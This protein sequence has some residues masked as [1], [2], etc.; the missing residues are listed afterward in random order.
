V[1]N[2]T[3]IYD[4]IVVGGGT[5]GCVIASRL[6]EDPTVRVL[7]LEAGASEPL[8]AMST[9]PA[10]PTLVRSSASWAGSTVLQSSTGTAAFFPRGR[11]LGGSSSINAMLFA[12]GHRASYEPW[13]AAGGTEWSFE[14]LLPYFARSEHTDRGAPSRGVNGPLSVAPASSPNPVLTACL[15]AAIESGHRRAFDI[16]GGLEEGFSPCDLNI[17]AGKRQSAADAY[18]S[19]AIGRPNLVVMV[20]TL[21]RR[22][23]IERGICTGVEFTTPAGGDSFAIGFEIVLTAGAI[24]S[25]QLLMLSG[26]GP[27]EHLESVGIRAALDLPGVGSNLQDHPRANL[28]YRA[29]HPVPDARNNHGEIIGLVRSS[30]AQ[31]APDIQMVFV[32]VPILAPSTV[33]TPH[34]Y[35]LGVS[36]M[37]PFSRGTVRLADSKPTSA[38]LIDPNYFS[39]ERDMQTMVAGLRL[40]RRIGNAPPLDPWR[41][42]ETAPG[43]NV[44]DDQELRSFVRRTLASYCHPVGTC[45]FGGGKFSVVDP[46]LRV[47][48]M[49]GLRVADAAVF[50]TI[51][52]ANTN[53][54][55]YAVAERA[56]ELLRL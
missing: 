37:T 7:L 8:H 28:V 33:S 20:D 10:W 3:N 53:A 34:G 6:S 44:M 47:N 12:R 51:P 17:V 9:P 48:G 46:Q 4:F 26:I 52:S 49:R 43:A 21:V 11:A 5:A 55:V 24:G 39:D 40:A 56:A 35:T 25:P 2:K 1:L 19:R 32:D 31:T 41:G 22:L 36:V 23:R 38:P 16:S 42:E 15:Q 30:P 54:T 29:A 13:E 45:A 18:L 14:A 50:P 27:C